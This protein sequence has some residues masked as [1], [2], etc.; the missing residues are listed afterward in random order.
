MTSS[1]RGSGLRSPAGSV[2]SRLYPSRILSRI[3][4]VGSRSPSP[5]VVGCGRLSR[6]RG[7]RKSFPR[8]F[9][10][11]IRA[12]A[13]RGV[14]SSAGRLGSPSCGSTRTCSPAVTLYYSIVYAIP[15]QGQIQDFCGRAE[16]RSEPSRVADGYQSMVCVLQ[17]QDFRDR[18]IR[19]ELLRVAD[20]RRESLSVD[21]LQR[22]L[23]CGRSDS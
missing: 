1:V 21:W 19:S 6:R 23:S 10:A 17:I 8:W 4:V 20:S 9:L 5:G 3:S 2:L 18:K 12:P 22:L 15:I 14:Q 7:P 11:S 16:S 13:R